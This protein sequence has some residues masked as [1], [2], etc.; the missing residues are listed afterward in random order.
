MMTRA[1]VVRVAQLGGPEMMRLMQE[2]LPPPGLGQVQV[3]H[4]AIGFNYIDIYQRS[5]IYPLELPSGLGHEAAGVVEAIGDGVHGLAVGDRVVYMN[6]GIGAYA[7]HRNLAVDKL[8]QLPEFIGDELAAA[9]FFKAMTAQYLVKKTYRVQCGD[10]VL[11][12]AAAGGV[13]QILAAW[14]KSIGAK[15]IG[16]VGSDTKID[17]AKRAGCDIVINYSQSDWVRQ[18]QEATEGRKA[19]VVYDSVAKDTFMGSLDCAAPFGMVVLYGAASGPAPAIAPELLNKK[20]CLFLTRPSV[21]PHNATAELL[22]TNAHDVITAIQAGHIGISIGARYPLSK[23][24]EAHEFAQARKLTGAMLLIPQD[25]K[26]K[27]L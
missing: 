17:A 15:V 22:R 18:V 3:R 8:I 7:S 2:N 24:S 21:F 23:A 9:I 13:G 6:A 4:T 5:G 27:R 10:T 11:I 12:H 19:N 1:D 14:T 20:G 26:D 25:L 16:T